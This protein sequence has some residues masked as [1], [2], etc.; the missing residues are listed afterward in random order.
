MTD[1]HLQSGR[2]AVCGLDVFSLDEAC[3]LW[4]ARF[5]TFKHFKR[6]VI[7]HPALKPLESFVQE[8]WED[9]RPITTAEAFLEQNMEKRRVMFDCIGVSKIFRDLEPELLDKQTLHKTRVRWDANN[10]PYD[11][12]YQ[13]NYELYKIDYQKLFTGEIPF[14]RR[15]P[16]YAV[17]CWCT[18]TGREYWIYIP[19]DAAMGS[20]SVPDAVRAIARTI[21]IDIT[22]PK[23][24]FRQGD[25]IIAEE[26]DLSTP[27]EP[28]HL[29]KEQ[30]LELVYSET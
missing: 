10:Q 14:S 13:D 24:I 4:K 16:V 18:T 15:R 25:I 7:K 8:I 5:E 23:R 22:H 30:Y 9:I 21:R 28:Y 19:E 17:R 26:S 29:T 11:Y 27:C 2:Y 12:A 6:D 20:S 3:R 1:Y